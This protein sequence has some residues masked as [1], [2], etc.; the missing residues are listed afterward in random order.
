MNR[1]VHFEI[2]AKD[3]DGMQKFYQDVFGWDI[4]DMGAEMG[5]YRMIVTGKDAADTKWPGINGGMTPRRGNPP[6]GG[7]PVNA[8][9]STISVENLGDILGKIKTAGGS[10][11]LDP[12]DVPGVGNLAYAKDIEGNIFG[13]LQ[14]K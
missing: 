10:I 5:N 2:H 13:V 1:I 6:A 4:K 7:E 14:P 9:V 11:A 3:L 12:M 8:Y